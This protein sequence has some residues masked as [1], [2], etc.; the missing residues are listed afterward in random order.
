MP[1]ISEGTWCWQS[2]LSQSPEI[3]L[4]DRVSTRFPHLNRY[5]ERFADTNA[6]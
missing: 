6:K 4:L 1:V 2:A 5:S 3:P